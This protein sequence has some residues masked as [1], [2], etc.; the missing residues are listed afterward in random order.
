ML[1]RWTPFTETDRLSQ[2]MNRLLDG[3][4][5]ASTAVSWS[6]AIDVAEDKEQITLRARL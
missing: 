4:T 6:P 1:V 3:R 5:D 2:A